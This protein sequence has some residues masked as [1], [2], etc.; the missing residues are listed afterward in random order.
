MQTCPV[1]G[2]EF[3]ASTR[4]CPACGTNLQQQS[5]AS[6]P[7]PQSGYSQGYS[8]SQQGT[9]VPRTDQPHGHRKYVVA[10]IVALLIGL[11]V[12]GIIGFEFPV[13]ADFT[14]V[15]GTV[16]LSG[17]QAG[18]PDL[19]WFNSTTFGS[20]SSS[21]STNHAYMVNLPIGD[22]YSVSILWLNATRFPF[23]CAASPSTFSSNNQNA[24][25]NFSC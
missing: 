20:L 9:A 5:F 11:I 3:Q 10:I 13:A 21:V 18:T 15:K 22:T 7:I 2:K 19:I 4:Y 14:T 24:A 16:S 1:C 12:G 25:Q 23:T 17:S 8:Y 6:P